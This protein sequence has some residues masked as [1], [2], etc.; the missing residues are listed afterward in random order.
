MTRRAL[1]VAVPLICIVAL[2]AFW[3]F[4]KSDR[5]LTH[6]IPSRTAVG[7]TTAEP[8]SSSR[9]AIR[10]ESSGDRET[11]GSTRVRQLALR[12][13]T[14]TQQRAAESDPQLLAVK[15]V[16]RDY[17]AALGENP[18]GTNSEITKALLGANSRQARFI[19]EEAKVGNGQLVDRWNHPY[20]FHQLSRS[21]LQIRS[22]GPD[23]KMWTA[24]D[25]VSR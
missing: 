16:I 15:Q 1:V 12:F 24:D 8:R 9:S 4:R 22:A 3:N 20:F 7:S 13:D 21:Q 23:G 25:E 19:P 10:A 5:A 18:V 2:A 6:S 14:L 17:R 11:N